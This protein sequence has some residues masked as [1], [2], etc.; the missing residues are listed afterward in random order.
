MRLDRY[1]VER[2]YFESRTKAC[3]AI[4]SGRVKVGGKCVKPSH[5]VGE[6]SLVEVEES[7]DYVSRAAYKLKGFL[8]AS[9]IDLTKKS[10]LDIGSSTGGFTQ[11]LLEAGAGEVVCVDVGKGQLHPKLREDNRVK[12][13]EECDIR[14]FT[15][16]K[17]FE[18]VTCDV[19]F[20]SLLHII[21][22]I[23]RLSCGEII[24]L[25]KPQFE[26]GKKAKRNA[27]GVVVDNEAIV[28]ARQRFEEACRTLGW[29]LKAK[30]PS[31][32]SGKEG[33]VEYLYRFCKVS[34]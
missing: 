31:T 26:V 27:K 29:Q 14:T 11:V 2:G 8:D 23:D 24:L 13:Y 19:S 32:L 16:S 21:E 5:E 25:F 7:H 6:Q 10:V 33:N 12:V 3:E 20:I 9:A 4:K 18:V 17:P 30:Q 28:M 34:V 15:S 1:L 22:T